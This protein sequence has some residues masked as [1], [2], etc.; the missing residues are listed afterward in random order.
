MAKMLLVGDGGVGK[1]SWVLGM[2]GE[3]LDRRYIATKG[4]KK[5]MIEGMEMYDVGGQYKY[6]IDI[7]GEYEKII[8]MFDVCNRLSFNNTGWWYSKVLKNLASGGSIVLCGAK[9]D[10]MA[11]KVSDEE[12]SNVS[13]YYTKKCTIS[14]KNGTNMNAPFE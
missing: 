14:S 9:E 13:E 12:I 1:S 7:E 6:N 8:I 5:E 3:E 4:I 10:H 11:R 2:S